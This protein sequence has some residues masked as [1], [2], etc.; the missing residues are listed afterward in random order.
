VV[1]SVR[2]EQVKNGVHTVQET[3]D[4][5]MVEELSFHGTLGF[6]PNQHTVF[7]QP[8]ELAPALT[9]D[10]MYTVE[11]SKRQGVHNLLALTSLLN[12]GYFT[13]LVQDPSDIPSKETLELMVQNS[14]QI[15]A[16][17]KETYSSLIDDSFNEI[18]SLMTDIVTNR[19]TKVKKVGNRVELLQ[20]NLELATTDSDIFNDEI[21]ASGGTL[22]L[23]QSTLASG[24]SISEG[25]NLK[26]DINESI[27]GSTL[28]ISGGRLIITNTDQPNPDTVPNTSLTHSTIDQNPCDAQYDI[29]SFKTV[30]GEFD[31]IIL[32][33]AP[34][35]CEWDTRKIYSDGQLRLSDMTI[36][37][38]QFNDSAGVL[39][40]P[41][42]LPVGTSLQLGVTY[43]ADYLNKTATILIYNMLGVLQVKQQVVLKEEPGKLMSYSQIDVL[44]TAFHSMSVGGYSIIILVDGKLFGK[45][46]LG[47]IPKPL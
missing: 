2:T 25:A 6:D 29:F 30:S 26:F 15:E 34:E 22:I 10:H 11:L 18:Q 38:T 13:E 31:D 41:S 3:I 16:T 14:T 35:G 32:P 27:S 8:I 28:I 21:N 20:G 9:F 17:N 42:P 24:L 39:A 23:H 33:D 7:A 44:P 46:K 12:A 47:I 5:I 37:V 4:N 40:Y 43:P 1:I 45:T 36:E 19:V